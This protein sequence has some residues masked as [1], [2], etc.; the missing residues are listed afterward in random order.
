MN[1]RFLSYLMATEGIMASPLISS[2]YDSLVDHHIM[3]L[4]PGAKIFPVGS[5]SKCGVPIDCAR[6]IVQILWNRSFF[7][8]SIDY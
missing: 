7:S 2:R 1:V 8:C 3:V 4:G 6:C 5:C